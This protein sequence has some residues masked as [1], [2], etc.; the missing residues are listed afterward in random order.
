MSRAVAIGDALELAGYALAGVQVSGA[1]TDADVLSAFE[2]LPDDS[3][4][5]ILTPNAHAVLVDR[6]EE[7]SEL[8][9][10]VLPT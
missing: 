9:Y 6:L 8:V 10:T 3:R 7:R 2:A 5:I 1:S 4:L